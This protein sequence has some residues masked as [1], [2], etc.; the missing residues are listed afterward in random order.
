MA[1]TGDRYEGTFGG[2]KIELVRNNLDKTL[3]LLI[4][5]TVVASERR[6]LPKDITL[7]AEFEHEGAMHTAVAHQH[8]KPLLGLPIDSDDSI[9]IDGKPLPLKK[10]K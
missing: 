9:E 10:T 7:H 6:W 3:S 1:I 5:G 4:D 8:L 2:H